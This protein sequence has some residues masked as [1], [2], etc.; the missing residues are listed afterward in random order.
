METEKNQFFKKAIAQSREYFNDKDKV[1]NTLDR[2]FHKV[3]HLEDGKSELSGLIGKVKLFI[4]MI[5]AY[6]KGEYRE[7]PW[8]TVLILMAGLI[9]FL[10][11][12]DLISD[13][14]PGI[15]YVD[16]IAI[17]LYIFKSVEEDIEKFEHYLISGGSRSL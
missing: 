5:S 12:F 16:D 4:Q 15:G 7:I 3:L 1:L 17:I 8:K 2:A 6:V 13:F 9:Y 14:I 10:N 11:P